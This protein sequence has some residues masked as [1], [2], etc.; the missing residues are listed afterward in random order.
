MS[1]ALFSMAVAGAILGVIALGR[2]LSGPSKIPASPEALARGR[3]IAER[4]KQLIRPTLVLIPA[5]RLGFSKLGGAPELPTGAAWPSGSDG[6]LAFVAQLDLAELRQTGGPEWLPQKGALYAFYDEE[7]AGRADHTRILFSP[8]AERAPL[9]PPAALPKRLRFAE[10]RVGFRR[11]L[12]IPSPQWLGVDVREIDFGDADLDVLNEA[13]SDSLGDRPQHRVGGY[14]AEIQEAR[15]PLECEHLSRGLRPP[16]YGEDVAPDVQR[17][18]EEW[19]LLLQVDSD[20]ALGM[21][22]G[23]AGRLY[24]FVREADARVADFSHTVALWQTY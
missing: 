2:L 10:R 7:G 23:D 11:T 17:A 24:V 19:R 22:W 20:R 14:P 12:S 5:E 3:E 18:A 8:D 4:L 1:W 13:V 9:A 21:N 15:M 6:P 16:A